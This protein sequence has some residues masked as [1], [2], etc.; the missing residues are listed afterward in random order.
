[1]HTFALCYENDDKSAYVQISKPE[2]DNG[3]TC[4]DS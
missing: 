2:V 3:M 1:M 4:S